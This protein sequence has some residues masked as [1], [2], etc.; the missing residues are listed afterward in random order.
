MI[1]HCKTSNLNNSFDLNLKT[2]FLHREF[3][4]DDVPLHNNLKSSIDIR[5]DTNIHFN[6]NQKLINFN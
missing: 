1:R 3:F 4:I 6:F 2:I 5:I